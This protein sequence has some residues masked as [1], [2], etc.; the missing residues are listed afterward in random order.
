MTGFV[1]LFSVIAQSNSPFTGALPTLLLYHAKMKNGT[2][3]S[4]GSGSGSIEALLES[5][6]SDDFELVPIAKISPTEIRLNGTNNGT[7]YIYDRS[8]HARVPIDLTPFWR[9]ISEEQQLEKG[10]SPLGGIS[11]SPIHSIVGV[12]VGAD[13][14]INYHVRVSGTYVVKY[15]P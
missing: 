13:D 2:T 1:D 14:G 8:F 4:T 11:S 15:V 5:A 12:L 3:V 9:Q 7:S 10:L 6:I